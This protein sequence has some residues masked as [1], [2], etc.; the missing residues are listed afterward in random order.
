MFQPERIGK[1]WQVPNVVFG[2]GFVRDAGR[3]LFYYGW[4]RQTRRR[5]EAHKR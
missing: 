2:R 4:R 1:N 3:W 5:V